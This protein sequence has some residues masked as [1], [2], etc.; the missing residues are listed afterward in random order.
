MKTLILLRHGESEWNSRNL[1][2]G[3][4]DIGLTGVGEEQARHAGR[5]LRAAGLLPDEVHTSVLTRAVRSAGLV[6]AAAEAADV[7]VTTHWRLN[8]RHYGALQG[9]DRAAVLARYGERRYRHWR[10]SYDGTPPPIDP[11]E[12]RALADDPRYAEL[13]GRLPRT[14]SLAD[15]TARLQ[16]CWRGVLAPALRT[17]RRVLVVAHSNS[18]RALAAHLDG[19]DHAEI[20]TLDIPTGMPLRYDLDD[21]LVPLVRGG[22]YLEPEIAARRAAA[23][24]EEGH[25]RPEGSVRGRR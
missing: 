19:L 3:W 9:R 15:V 2:A 17:G 24:A 16:P 22:R 12:Q 14:E 8:E 11:A 5:L 6:L 20:M 4:A 13:A 18:L 7:P 23:V 1:F 25:R 21:D 10:R